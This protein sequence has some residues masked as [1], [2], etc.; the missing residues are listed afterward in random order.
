MTNNLNNFSYNIIIANLHEMHSFLSKEINKKYKKK[1]ILE[2]YEKILI[3]IM[4]II[5]HFSCECLKLLKINGELNWPTYNEKLL[6]ENFVNFV[7]QINGKKRGLIKGSK[8]IKEEELMNKINEE[9][10][11]FKYL[12]NKKIKKKIFIPNKLINIIV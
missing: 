7:V 11:L 5:P 4:P 12:E 2:N 3:S 9:K 8:D 1:T 6:E 10:N